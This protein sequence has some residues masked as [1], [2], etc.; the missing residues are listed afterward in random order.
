MSKFG[1]AADWFEGF[2]EEDPY[3]NDGP[4]WV[5]DRLNEQLWSKQ[6]EIMNSVRDHKQTAVHACHA[7]GK[8]FLAARIAAWWIETH[9]LETAFVVTSAPTAHQ[10]R[11]ILWREISRAHRQ[12]NLLG[13]LNQTEWVTDQGVT[14]GYG[15]KP[16]D[17]D[18][19]GFQGIHDEYVLVILDEASGIPESLYDGAMKITTGPN[20]RTLAIGNPDHEGSIFHRE[21]M[22]DRWNRIHVSAYDSPNFT[23]EAPPAGTES[24]LISQG[25]VDDVAAKYGKDSPKYKS[26][27]LGEFPSEKTDGV[28]ARADLHTALSNRLPADDGDEVVFGI[29]VAGAGD[30]DTVVAVREGLRLV[31]LIPVRETSAEAN[32]DALIRLVREWDPDLINIDP[33]GVGDG[34]MAALRREFPKLARSIVGVNF[35]E[36]ASDPKRWV[37]LRSEVHWYAREN[38]ADWDLTLIANDHD[39]QE[40]LLA[41]RW[42]EQHRRKHAPVQVEAK[43][44]IRRAIGRSPDSSDAIQI[45]YWP[46]KRRKKSSAAAGGVWSSSTAQ[47]LTRPSYG[48]PG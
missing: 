18:E 19:A 48:I 8:S 39:V 10:V 16:A 42:F 34:H 1:G 4:G 31:A 40:E 15:R 26:M 30:D 17:Y 9:P 24:L 46:S 14:L 23:D 43:D 20:C 22:S 21:C 6:V 32:Q 13:R 3:V 27:V 36:A 11:T 28:I 41:A 37:N 25:F 29:D 33:I 5:T 47:G 7:I 45:A 2:D 38:I 35:S 44:E 12:G